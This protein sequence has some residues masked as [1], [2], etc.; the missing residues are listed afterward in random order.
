[1]NLLVASQ[2][3]VDRGSGILL[4]AFGV[5]ARN[6]MVLGKLV[7]GAATKLAGHSFMFKPCPSPEV[8][9]CLRGN[10]SSRAG[11]GIR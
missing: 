6:Q 4:A 3:D 2:A 11:L 8:E 10:Y 1:M 9:F 5:L 7:D